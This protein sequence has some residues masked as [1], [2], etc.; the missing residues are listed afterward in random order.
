VR[1]VHLALQPAR[2]FLRGRQSARAKSDSAAILLTACRRRKTL[3]QRWWPAGVGSSDGGT[4][5]D[6]KRSRDGPADASLSAGTASGVEVKDP[7]S[8]PAAAA[9]PDGATEFDALENSAH[10]AM[11]AAERVLSAVADKPGQISAT[12]ASDAK[13]VRGL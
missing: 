12:A 8:A 4:D 6:S 3:V 13:Q 11:S 1:E 9:K 2:E 7:G 10:E 5:A